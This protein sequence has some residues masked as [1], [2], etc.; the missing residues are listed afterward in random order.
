MQGKYTIYKAG[1]IERNLL[2]QDLMKYCKHT[3]EV[4]PFKDAVCYKEEGQ[5]SMFYEFKLKGKSYI[6]ECK[7]KGFG[8]EYSEI[9]ELEDTNE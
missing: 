9:F 3:H 8:V 4:I 5:F 2:E 6:I 7:P 1:S